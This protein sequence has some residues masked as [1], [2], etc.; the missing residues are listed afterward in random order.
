V[1]RQWHATL[2][3]SKFQQTGTYDTQKTTGRMKLPFCVTSTRYTQSMSAVRT[4]R[5][6]TAK[7][8]QSSSYNGCTQGTSYWDSD[9]KVDWVK[10]PCSFYSS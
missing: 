4:S 1:A 3:E 2:K 8:S 6:E 5:A 9:A 10:Y 7:Y